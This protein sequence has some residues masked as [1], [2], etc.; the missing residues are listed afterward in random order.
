MDCRKR[1]VGSGGKGIRKVILN[2]NLYIFININYNLYDFYV[3]TFANLLANHTHN[4]Y[5]EYILIASLILNRAKIRCESLS[6]QYKNAMGRV[7]VG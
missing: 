2:Q 1:N 3:N 6:C 5:L 4:F 7:R